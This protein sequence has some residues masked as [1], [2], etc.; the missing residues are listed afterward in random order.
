[1][2]AMKPVPEL[3]SDH[4]VSSHQD[5]SQWLGFGIFI[6]ITALLPFVIGQ[7]YLYVVTQVMIYA[8]ATLGLDVLYGRTGQLSLAHA[9]FFGIGAYVAALSNTFGV[10]VVLQ[11]VLV[12]GLAVIVGAL[13]AI[14]TLRLSGLRL[15]LVTLLFGELFVWLIDHASNLTGGSQGMTVQPLTLGPFD[16]SE[17]LDGY[18]LAAIASLLATVMC[19]QLGKTQYGRRMLAVRDS[20]LASASVGIPIV[21]TKIAA[22]ILSAI[23][24]GAAGWIYAYVVG[25]VSPTTFDLFGSVNFLVAVIL[26]GSGRVLGAWCGALYIVLVPEVFSSIGY[27]NLFPIVGGAVMIVVAMTIP[28]GLVGSLEKLGETLWAV[29][30]RR[31]R[32]GG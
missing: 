25:F 3:V 16:S 22:F 26:G 28:G 21:R 29:R 1:M 10:P 27:P 13:V 5:R 15:A 9:S 17:P 31:G 30:G 11:P 23:L 7:Y 2:N 14:P 12:L 18:A 19:V 24:A 4:S 20:E 32:A 8:I 6:V